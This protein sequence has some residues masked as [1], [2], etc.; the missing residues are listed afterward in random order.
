[1]K[2][3][4]TVEYCKPATEMVHIDTALIMM[5]IIVAVRLHRESA[6]LL[7]CSQSH[8]LI[9]VHVESFKISTSPSSVP[10]VLLS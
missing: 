7:L 4:K 1:M 3:Q 2:N 10:N 5:C 9:S 8:V 6:L